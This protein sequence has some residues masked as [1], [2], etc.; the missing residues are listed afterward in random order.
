MLQKFKKLIKFVKLQL[1]RLW[2]KLRLPLSTKAKIG[3]KLVT[4]HNVS[5]SFITEQIAYYG[6]EGYEFE[7]GKFISTYPFPF[8]TFIDGGANIGF[9]SILV[10]ALH[11]E[12]V[13]ITAIEAFANNVEYI[14]K[15]QNKNEVNFNIIPCALTER[16]GDIKKFY[17]PTSHRSSKLAPAASLINNFK[18]SGGI[19]NNDSY[20][21]INV[22][23]ISLKDVI[24]SSEGPYLIKLDIEGYELP[25]LQ[26]T[27]DTLKS[28]DDID[29]IIELM[30]NDQ[31]KKEVFDFLISCGS[32]GYLISNAGLIAEDRPLTLPYF[33]QRNGQLRTCWKNHYFTKRAKSCIESLSHE[34][35]GYFV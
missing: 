31:D 33:T 1:I 22:E 35:F 5:D 2:I 34:H 23:T 10:R 26:A 12:H 3:K 19:F 20:E 7:L 13:S 15:L 24:K 25:V 32:E 14:K 6:I 28:R 29:L 18:G 17:V 4:F 11:G 21:T 8:K 16:S 9:Y 30:I 27:K